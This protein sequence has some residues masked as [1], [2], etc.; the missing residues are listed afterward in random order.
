MLSCLV[1]IAQAILIY[2]TPPVN[3]T[4]IQIFKKLLILMYFLCK[5]PPLNPYEREVIYGYANQQRL[6][7]RPL[8]KKKRGLSLL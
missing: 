1:V 8:E 4:L 5:I 6:E 2:L 3:Q 7:R